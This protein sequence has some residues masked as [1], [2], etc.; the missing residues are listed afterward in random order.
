MGKTK[1]IFTKLKS[2]VI[3]LLVMAFSITCI[4]PVIWMLYSSVKTNPEFNRN[5]LSLPKSDSF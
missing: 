3:N 5:I 4:Y 1:S 2:I